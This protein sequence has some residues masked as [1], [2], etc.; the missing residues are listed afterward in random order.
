MPNIKKGRGRK[1][2]SS[3]W[4][5]FW[6]SVSVFE[7]YVISREQWEYIKRSYGVAKKTLL[8]SRRNSKASIYFHFNESEGITLKDWAD[9]QG[10]RL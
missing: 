9:K 3:K 6:L 10:V 2:G 5:M 1:P 4:V 7:G 8:E